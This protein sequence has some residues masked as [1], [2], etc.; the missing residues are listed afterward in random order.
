MKGNPWLVILVIVV[1]VALILGFSIGDVWQYIIDFMKEGI[2]F[3][4]YWLN[5]LVE[6]LRDSIVSVTS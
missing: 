2:H 3:V 5:D 6:A 4:V 1:I